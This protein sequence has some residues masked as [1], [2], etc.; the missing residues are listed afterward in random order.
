M[1]LES[2]SFPYLDVNGIGQIVFEK[3][4]I[5]IIT[6]VFNF[7]ELKNMSNFYIVC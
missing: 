7:S 4:Y 5:R 2:S 1:W 6:R 3:V